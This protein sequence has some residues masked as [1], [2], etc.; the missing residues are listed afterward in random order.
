MGLCSMRVCTS[1]MVC[2]HSTVSYVG[3]RRAFH[4]DEALFFIPREPQISFFLVVLYIFLILAVFLSKIEIKFIQ[5]LT[6]RIYLSL[7]R[8]CRHS[9]KMFIPYI[10]CSTQLH[11]LPSN[12]SYKRLYPPIFPNCESMP[13]SIKILRPKGA[14]CAAS[15]WSFFISRG[16]GVKIL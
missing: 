2:P 9:S 4:I 8:Y 15:T 6:L 10:A 12:H 5:G 11:F 1:Y 13:L 3:G 7:M 14:F 16:L